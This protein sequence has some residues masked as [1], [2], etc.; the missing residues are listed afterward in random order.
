M[1]TVFINAL[2]ENQNKIKLE[3]NCVVFLLKITD[4]HI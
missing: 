2:L 3:Y 1:S 4:C